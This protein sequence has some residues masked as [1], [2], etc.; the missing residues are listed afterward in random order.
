MKKIKIIYWIS[1]GLFC[2]FLFLTSISY[3]TDPN[4]I[5]VFNHLGFPQYFRIEL[6]FAKIVGTLILL[7]PI[8]PNK[9]KE[10]AY[11]G[12]GITLLSGAVA[13]LCVSDPIGYTINVVF[14]FI[15]LGISKLYL[16][17]L[18][19]KKLESNG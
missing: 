17:K 7:I 19:Q 5:N 1:T 3:F 18:N 2:A 10:W 8:I 9:Y 11:V 12:F 14:W 15:L 16:N 4:F 13:H 6:G